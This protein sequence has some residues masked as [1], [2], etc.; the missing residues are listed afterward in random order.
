M[1]IATEGPF[2][3]DFALYSLIDLATMHGNMMSTV[4]AWQHI[5][6]NVEASESPTGKGGFQTLFYSHEGLSQEDVRFIEKRVF[7]L[8]GDHKPTKRIFATLPNG[9][10]VLGSVVPLDGRDSAGRKGRHLAHSYIIPRDQFDAHIDNVITFLTSIPFALSLDEVFAEGDKETGNIAPKLLNV[11][12]SP[13]TSSTKWQVPDLLLLLHLA[14][15]AEERAKEAKAVAFIGST[16][17]IEETLASTAILLPK[18]LLP[19]CTFD[20]VFQKWWECT[21]YLLLGCR[22]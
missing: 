9:N 4:T 5:Y 17:L 6:S 15:Q 16:D 20:T 3:L 22:I 7:Y 2:Y 14:M 8:P 1:G 12:L 13:R 19:A 11:G 10:I 18:V 21:S